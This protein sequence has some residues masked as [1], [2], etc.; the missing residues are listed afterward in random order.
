MNQLLNPFFL[1]ILSSAIIGLLVLNQQFDSS[2][3]M[4]NKVLF[5]ILSLAFLMVF[6]LHGYKKGTTYGLYITLFLWAFFV[7]TVPIPQVALLL[8]FPLKHFFDI[9][10]ITSQVIISFFAIVV[11]VYFH[12]KMKSLLQKHDMG[13][14]FQNIM[15]HRLYFIFVLS[16][17]GSVIGS[18]LIDSFVDIYVFRPEIKQPNEVMRNVLLSVVLFILLNIWYM[19]YSKKHGLSF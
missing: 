6:V 9:T 2:E 17:I 4:V 3:T 8:S 7:C 5:N 11:L 1:L 18:Y 15:K 19:N 16:V 13:K 12:F 10:M 14:M